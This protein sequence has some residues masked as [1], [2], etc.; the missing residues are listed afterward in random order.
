MFSFWLVKGPDRLTNRDRIGNSS[1]RITFKPNIS[2]VR[3]ESCSAKASFHFGVGANGLPAPSRAAPKKNGT[4][5]TEMPYVLSSGRY[6][7]VLVKPN[8]EYGDTRVV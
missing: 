4:M 2:P 7:T 8:H 6:L 5:S 1:G 3:F